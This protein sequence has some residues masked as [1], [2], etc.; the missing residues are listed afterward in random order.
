MN[1]Y[2][3]EFLR[4]QALDKCFRDKTKFYFI[5]DLAIACNKAVQEHYPTRI[6][7]RCRT[8]Y[9]EIEKMRKLPGFNESLEKSRILDE[10]KRDLDFLHPDD[11]KEI[12]PNHTKEAYS[13]KNKNSFSFSNNDLNDLETA[14]MR[15]AI[16]VMS[17]IKGRPGYE[18]LNEVILKLEK[19]LMQNEHLPAIMSYDENKNLLGLEYLED[20]I[21]AI[22]KK[23]PLKICYKP[24][25]FENEENVIV[26]P[27]YLK[28]Y[29][30]RWFLFGNRKDKPNLDYVPQFAIDRIKKIV[31]CHTEKEKFIES[32]VDIEDYL[33]HVIGVSTNFHLQPQNIILK[34]HP[35]R[36]DY[37]KTK[38]PH[39][40]KFI[41]EAN[42]TIQIRVVHNKELEQ[43][44]FSY[45][46]DI[47]VIAP[48]FL[49]N[50]L[51][52]L[53]EKMSKNYLQG[54]RE[55]IGNGVL[56]YK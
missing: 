45:G 5:E 54:Q 12:S 21:D 35:N 20:L 4:I 55:I 24:Y 6:N 26:Y 46:A 51:K 3:K 53:Y 39:E 49:K 47:K 14:Q 17:R 23:I 52:D 42:K 29:N 30:K 15:E 44:I 13:Y 50:R 36:F 38:P 9:L 40:V 48:E 10:N 32:T 25:K 56:P 41:D 31:P 7:S 11:L 37:V 8:I 34:F 1:I 16:S 2:T 22:N 43:L 33:K 28:Q 19:D 18:S 27:Y